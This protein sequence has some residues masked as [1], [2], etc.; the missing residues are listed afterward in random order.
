VFGIVDSSETRLQSSLILVAP[1]EMRGI[2]K[3]AKL[4]PARRGSVLIWILDPAVRD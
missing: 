4:L 2:T 1:Y 3:K